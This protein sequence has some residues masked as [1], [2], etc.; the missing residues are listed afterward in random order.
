MPIRVRPQEQRKPQS[1][2]QGSCHLVCSQCLVALACSLLILAG[3]GPLLSQSVG[4]LLPRHLRMDTET[5]DRLGPWFESTLAHTLRNLT[6]ERSYWIRIV[7][8]F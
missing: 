2:Q 3:L 4:D 5:S 8:K 7:K 6:T 1:Y